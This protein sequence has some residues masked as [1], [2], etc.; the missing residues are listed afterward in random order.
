M[1]EWRF[2]KQYDDLEQVAEFLPHFVSVLNALTAAGEYRYNDSFTGRIPGIEGPDEGRAIYLLQ[3]LDR[4]RTQ[5]ARVAE[6]V[7]AGY[8]HVTEATHTHR[9]GH[10]V[11]YS[12][13]R[14]GGTWE[15]FRNAR[16]IPSRTGSKPYAVLPK[17]KRANGWL[18][19]GRNV[20]VSA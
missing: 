15:E 13:N 11:L 1:S 5:A 7:Q 2:N 16:L 17:G 18:V 20:L 9:Y 4:V 6:L 10:I 12:P 19:S 3:G 8:V 14:N